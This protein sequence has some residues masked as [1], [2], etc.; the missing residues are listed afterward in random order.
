MLGS[1]LETAF[2]K[3]IFLLASLEVLLYHAARLA[4]VFPLIILF[5]AGTCTKNPHR[6]HYTALFWGRF[7]GGNDLPWRDLSEGHGLEDFEICRFRALHPCLGSAASGSQAPV[8]VPE[9][10]RGICADP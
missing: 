5:L 4:S 8:P 9:T 7:S 6:K 10:N 3:V 2:R 1:R